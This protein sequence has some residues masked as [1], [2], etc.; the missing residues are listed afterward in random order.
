MARHSVIADI[1]ETLEAAIT[2]AMLPLAVDEPPRAVVSD[3]IEEPSTPPASMALFLYEVS[4]DTVT[5]NRPPVREDTNQ[6]LRLRKPPLN[7]ILRYMLTPYG[8]TRDTEQRMLAL[9]MQALYDRPILSGPDL[10]GDPV[11]DGGLRGSNASIKLS[12]AVLTLE[13]RT[14]IWHSVQQPYRLSVVYEARLAELESEA[15]VPAEI[16]RTR[17]LE[18]AEP[19]P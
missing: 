9:T 3:H 12:L 16:V 13:E 14:R 5:R 17:I 6:G 11:D 18:Q 2:A 4:Q 10:R 7:L 8:G 19:A 1:S 15:V